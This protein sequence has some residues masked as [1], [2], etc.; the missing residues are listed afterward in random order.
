[1]DL[2]QVQEKT[3]P[4]CHLGNV[5]FGADLEQVLELDQGQWFTENDFER[6]AAGGLS[7]HTTSDSSCSELS[8][9]VILLTM[10]LLED[11]FSSQVKVWY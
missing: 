11:M 8:K 4:P 2:G 9:G 10:P 6:P 3:S 1:M 7:P 5:G